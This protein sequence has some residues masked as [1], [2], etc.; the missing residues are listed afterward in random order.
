MC[1]YFIPF[2]CWIIFLCMDVGGGG[3]VAARLCLT[4]RTPWTVS[5]RLLCSRDF[6]GKKTGVGC[7]YLLQYEYIRF[8]LFINQFM[9]SLFSYM[10]NTAINID[11][12][13]FVWMYVLISLGHMPRY[14]I[15]K[16]YSNSV[17]SIWRNC[18]T[19]FQSSYTILWSNQLPI[20][21]HLCQHLL[22]P[23][24]FISAF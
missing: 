10:G 20:S 13:T 21:P 18:Q 22:L 23:V 11:I 3:Y 24:F 5:S 7:H 9:L 15:T 8:Y 6:P 19:L 16:S 4:L 2:N 12:Q 17:C 14:K 1:Q